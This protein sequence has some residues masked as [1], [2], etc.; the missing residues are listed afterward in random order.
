MNRSSI[1]L[2]ASEVR[3]LARVINRPSCEFYVVGIS[4]HPARDDDPDNRRPAKLAHWRAEG[5]G[6][7]HEAPTPEDAA[8]GV[9]S[10]LRAEIDAKLESARAQVANLES[11]RA[12]RT[13]MRI[14]GS[15]PKL[16]AAAAQ[17]ASVPERRIDLGT[18]NPPDRRRGVRAAGHGRAVIAGGPSDA[19]DGPVDD[20]EEI[21]RPGATS[22]GT[23]RDS[24]S[25]IQ[26]QGRRSGDGDE[27]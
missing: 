13:S 16:P 8:A 1:V 26:A 21:A 23:K 19:R 10:R 4:H 22:R 6:F 15:P 3:R 17:S 20:R 9:L 24:S 12:G 25:T 18:S 2:W 7:A 11:A 5:G 27:G 14:G